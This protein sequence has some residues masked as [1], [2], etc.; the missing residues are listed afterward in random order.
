MPPLKL[1]SLCAGKGTRSRISLARARIIFTLEG[2][3]NLPSMLVYTVVQSEES[4]R[5][6]SCPPQT[7]NEKEGEETQSRGV[8]N[9]HETRSCATKIPQKP[10]QHLVHQK[11]DATPRFEPPKLNLLCGSSGLV[12]HAQRVPTLGIGHIWNGSCRYPIELKKWT[13]SGRR[14]SETA[15]ECTGAV[16]QEGRRFDQLCRGE[17]LGGSTRS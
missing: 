14:K 11:T 4:T 5:N 6:V 16:R 15:S 3:S 1:A 13:W 8:R 2:E 10:S 9:S 7:R 17:G 12:E